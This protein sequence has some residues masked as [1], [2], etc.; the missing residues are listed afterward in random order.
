MARSRE[1]RKR[2][3]K[4]PERVKRFRDAVLEAAVSGRLTQE[5]RERARLQ[6]PSESDWPQLAN[7]CSKGRVITH[8][9]IK[10]GE[11][12]RNGVPC[13]RTSNVRWLHLDTDGMKLIDPELSARYPRT[14]LKGSEVLVNVRGTLGG[15][16]AV[17]PNMR[18][19]NVSREVAVVPADGARINPRFLALWIAA[20]RSQSWLQRVQKGVAY[21]GI[22]IEDLRTLP[23][24]V[25]SAREQAEILKR[26]M[27]LF[28]LAERIEQR[29]QIATRRVECLS[30]AIL[31][32][33]FRG[34]LVPQDSAEEPAKETLERINGHQRT[35]ETNALRDATV[36]V[37]RPGREE[38]SVGGITR[39]A[40]RRRAA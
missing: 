24:A 3:E 16:F 5:W 27:A 10:L 31:E 1:C 18:G 19:W 13:L 36:T 39:R 25:P 30:P 40:K 6:F 35:A 34:E 9:V 29:H 15:V 17:T 28:E 22:N 23:V 14:V 12:V 11:P 37:R 26:V 38:A 32:R 4:V 2:L 33:A 8:E 21:T 20:R 7:L